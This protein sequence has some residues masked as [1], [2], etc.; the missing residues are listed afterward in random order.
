MRYLLEDPEDKLLDELG[1]VGMPVTHDD[2][3]YIEQRIYHDYVASVDYDL[4]EPA[5]REGVYD[6]P[7]R[8]YEQDLTHYPE[9]FKQ[10]QENYDQYERL[11]KRFEDEN[12]LEEQGENPYTRKIPRDMSPWEKKY[13]DF[14]P[15]YTGTSH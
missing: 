5:L 4:D 14:M 13:D 2:F 15:K 8:A 9:V 12:E 1:S 7:W 11:K 6:K 3:D 10:Y